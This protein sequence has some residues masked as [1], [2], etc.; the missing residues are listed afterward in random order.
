MAAHIWQDNAP[1]MEGGRGDRPGANSARGL[2]L[3]IVLAFAAIYLIWGSTY[4]GIR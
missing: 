1:V 4:L 3:R 2:R